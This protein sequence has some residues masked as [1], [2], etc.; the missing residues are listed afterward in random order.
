MFP[1][2]W[3]QLFTY[4][5]L[6]KNPFLWSQ[7]ESPLCPQFDGWTITAWLCF[8]AVL[9]SSSFL[10]CFFLVESFLAIKSDLS[11]SPSVVP[12]F[13]RNHFWK[14]R[15]LLDA[16]IKG[17]VALLW[18][19]WGFCSHPNISGKDNHILYEFSCIIICVR[20]LNLMVLILIIYYTM[21]QR[22]RQQAVFWAI[23]DPYI[24]IICNL[25]ES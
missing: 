14:Q 2:T 25:A 24:R 1:L 3:N 5:N 7:N 10:F 20:H 17:S 13:S 9:G 23:S 18:L 12:R 19:V 11:L 16:V 22:E 6:K 15:F 4:W 21:T 8:G